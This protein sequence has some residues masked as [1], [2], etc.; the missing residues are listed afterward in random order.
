MRSQR[1]EEAARLRDQLNL[2]SHTPAADLAGQAPLSSGFNTTHLSVA[3][4]DG[5]LVALTTTLNFSVILINI[6]KFLS[7]VD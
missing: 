5:S 2:K 3:D 6:K 1:Y 7:F 4:R